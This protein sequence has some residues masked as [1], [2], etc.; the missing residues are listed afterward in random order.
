[1]PEKADTARPVIRAGGSTALLGAVLV[2]LGGFVV[3]EALLGP[4]ASTYARVGP[5]FF[6]AVVGGGTILV[7]LILTAQALAGRWSMVLV[8]DTLPE[9]ATV[10]EDLPAI[11]RILLVVGGLLANL[12]LIGPFGFVVGSTVMFTLTTRAFGSR[13]LVRSAL[14]GVVFAGAIYLIFRYGLGLRLPGGTIWS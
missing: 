3:Y 8:D 9:G 4:A 14:I 5:G 6:P 2:L 13:N 11:S 10:R 1:M 7:G 12:L